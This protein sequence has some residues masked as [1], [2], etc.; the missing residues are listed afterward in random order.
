MSLK[1]VNKPPSDSGRGF[2]VVRLAGNNKIRT[3]FMCTDLRIGEMQTAEVLHS[4]LKYAADDDRYLTCDGGDYDPGLPR[5][6]YRTGFH[7]Y[8]ELKGAICSTWY[9]DASHN[10]PVMERRLGYRTVIVEVSYEDAIAYGEDGSDGCQ[11]N[12]PMCIVAGR[13]RTERIVSDAEIIAV[14]VRTALD[15]FT[16][17]V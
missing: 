3:A 15:N 14:L 13:I 9:R 4:Y 10:D 2:K 8:T 16:S 6:R 5:P 12:Q 11:P 1:Y 17:K 7:I